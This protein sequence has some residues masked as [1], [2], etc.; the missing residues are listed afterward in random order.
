MITVWTGFWASVAFF[1]MR[2]L[3]LLRI[4]KSEEVIGL[5]EAECGGQAYEIE[6]MNFL[7]YG[8]VASEPRLE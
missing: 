8:S 1:S 7:Q 2:G 6:N 3:K 4:S 5:D